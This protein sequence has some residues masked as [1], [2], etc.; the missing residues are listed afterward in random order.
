[1]QLI[2]LLEQKMNSILSG[3]LSILV[4]RLCEQYRTR[5]CLNLVKS[6]KTRNFKLVKHNLTT[7][8][9]TSFIDN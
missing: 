8:E 3:K 5:K 6:G 1:M 7:F 4:R 9:G 2:R